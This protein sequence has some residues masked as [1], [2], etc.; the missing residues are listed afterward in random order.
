[1][2]DLH[3]IQGLIFDCDGTLADTMPAHYSSWL[4]ILE[5]RGIPFSIDEFYSMGGMPSWRIV[6]KLA[7]RAGVQVDVDEVSRLKNAD[8]LN[9][10]PLV[11]P[12]EPVVAVA[13]AAAGKLPMAVATGS[14][15]WVAE[16]VLE[17]IGVAHL[18]AAVVTAEDVVRHKPDP[19]VFLEAAR[20]IRVA[21]DACLVFEDTDPGVEAGRRAGMRVIDIRTMP[22]VPQRRAAGT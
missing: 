11:R 21:P 14:L 18:F 7:R 5:P 16:R 2:I 19:D 12:I 6:E 13:R 10:I 4:A 8:F 3:G 22:G 20:R 1:M 15:R 9:H 17:Q